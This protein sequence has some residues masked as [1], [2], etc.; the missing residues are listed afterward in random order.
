[1]E[2]INYKVWVAFY[3][4]FANQL[5]KY[6]DDRKDLIKIVKQVYDNKKINLPTLDKDNNITDI[7]PFTIFAL[8]NKQIT[9]ENRITIATEFAKLLDMELEVP[10]EFDGI[11]L[12]MNLSATFYYFED[13]RGNNDIQILWDVFEGAI[14][15]SNN[16]NEENKKKFESAFDTALTQKGVKWNLTMGLFWIRPYSF[17]N[18]DTLNRNYLIEIKDIFDNYPKLKVDKVPK[19]DTYISLCDDVKN[20][21]ENIKYEFSNFPELSHY[22]YIKDDVVNYWWLNANPK[23]WSFSSINVGEKE[24][25]ELYNENGNKRRIFQ[26]FIDAKKDD[27]LVVYETSPMQ[28]IVGFAKIVKEQEDRKSVV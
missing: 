17:V 21:C 11:P 15:Y 2:N 25:Y 4:E 3:Q 12:A 14:D 18:L 20:L 27:I 9:K 23:I 8:F 24:S 13:E 5:L 26:N 6:K 1:M 22:A 16:S 7:D 19:F 28:K 10:T